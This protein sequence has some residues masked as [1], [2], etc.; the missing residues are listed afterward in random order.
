MNTVC[1]YC[2][3]SVEPAGEN[4]M[5]CGG[6]GTP[7]HVDCFEEN[8]GCTVFGCSAAPPDE[9]KI[10]VSGGDLTHQAIAQQQ[11]ES[12]PAPTVRIPA[13]P[14]P[15]IGAAADPH[16]ASPVPVFSRTSI[17][18][19]SPPP[20]M[21][22]PVVVR[23]A[24]PVDDFE[25]RD[26]RNRMTF[27][28]LGVLLGFFGAHNFYAGYRKKAIAQLLITVLTVGLA[29]PMIWIWAVIDVCTIER[30]NRGVRFQS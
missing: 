11:V 8:G 9:Q 7:H 29:G 20:V 18:F 4:G 15:W 1:P 6:C 12:S 23:Q 22:R 14:P 10:K 24:P 5:V 17:F 25:A 26:A 13:P 16:P 21:P 27:I 30:D 2:R 3:G 28:T 19:N